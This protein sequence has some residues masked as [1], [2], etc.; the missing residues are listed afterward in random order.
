MDSAAAPVAFAKFSPNSRYVLA[1]T[2]DDTLR[3]WNVEKCKVMKVY[4]GPRPPGTLPGS[5]VSCDAATETRC[6]AVKA[7]GARVFTHCAHLGAGVFK[8]LLLGEWLA[9]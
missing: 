8:L 1:A 9:S 4:Q 2:L 5:V 7:T 3:L 6:S